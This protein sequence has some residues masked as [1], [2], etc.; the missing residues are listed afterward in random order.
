MHFENTRTSRL[1]VSPSMAVSMKA[2]A[3]RAQGREVMDLSLGEPDFNTPGN[4]VEAAIHAMKDGMTHYTGPSGLMPLRE[5]IV[6]KFRREN[7]LD[8]TPA[9]VAI[10]IGAKQ[11]LF[12]LF[13]GV[14]SPGDEVIIPAPFWVSYRDMVT[15]NGGS[16]VILDCGIEQAFKLT[17]ERLAAALNPKTR[18]VMLNTPSNPSGIVYSRDELRALGDVL[19]GYPDVGII[20]DEIYEHILFPG[21]TFCS[22]PGA[23]PDLMDR[24]LV[25][26]GVSK[27]YAMTGWRLGYAVGPENL[28]KVLNKLESQ[29]VTCPSSI[30]QVAAAEALNG[31][32]AFITEALTAYAGRRDVV[33]RGLAR[34]DGLRTLVPQGAFYVFPHCGAYLGRTTPDGRVI[35]TDVDLAQYLLTDGGVAVVPGAA[36]GLSPYLRLS[37]ATSA[38]VLEKAVA[39]METS[40]RKLS[41]DQNA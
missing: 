9:Q 34:I 13:M 1:E 4:V 6:A 7:G 18:W 40:L 8:Y 12:N 33:I 3:L 25:I 22:F 26:N 31:T 16:A 41:Q 15:F 20:S 23:C 2:N 19:K 5:A 11:I 37:F 36:F 27:A 38:T 29:T 24:T 10:G 32:Q 35:A 28:I 21:A 14:L 30:S 17:P 39:A